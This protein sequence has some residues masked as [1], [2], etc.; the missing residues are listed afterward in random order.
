MTDLDDVLVR[1]IDFPP[2]L[3]NSPPMVDRIKDWALN[4]LTPPSKEAGLELSVSKS[5]A[6]KFNVGA[7]QQTDAGLEQLRKVQ[8]L[9]SSLNLNSPADQ[10]TQID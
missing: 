9:A 6:V 8:V 10:R 4:I 5:G 1:W 7:F 3:P 2:T